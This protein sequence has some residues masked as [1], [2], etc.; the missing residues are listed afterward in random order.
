MHKALITLTAV[1]IVVGSF[2]CKSTAPTEETFSP[3]AAVMAPVHQFVDAFNRGDMI[4]ALEACDEQMSIIDDVPPHEWHG[5]GAFTKWVY[6]YDDDAK[7]NGITEGF[8]KVHEPKHIH[9]TGDHAYVVVPATYTYKQHGK[10]V[11]ES[12]SILTVAL[13]KDESGWLITGWSWAQE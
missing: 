8:V 3:T 9:I 7:L 4:S 2:G 5:I 11:T 13:R 10:S 6:D 12:G 1:V